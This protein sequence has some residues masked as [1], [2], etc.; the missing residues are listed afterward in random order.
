MSELLAVSVKALPLTYRKL[1]VIYIGPEIGR[2]FVQRQTE[3]VCSRGHLYTSGLL[4]ANIGP[5]L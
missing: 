1:Y 4:T 5:F 2:W 3:L